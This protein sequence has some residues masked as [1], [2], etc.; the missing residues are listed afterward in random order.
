MDAS[1]LP[2]SD[3][4][5]QLVVGG[6]V[7]MDL[8]ESFAR[9]LRARRRA[10]AIVFRRNVADLVQVA[11]LCAA[12]RNAA[13][14]ELAPFVAVDQEGGRVSRLPE[15][16]LVLPPMRTLGRIDELGL[17]RRAARVVGLELGALGFN[18]DFAPVLDV[19]SN[20]ANPVIGDRSFGAEPERVARH[21][22]AFIEGLSSSGLCACAKHFPGHG[23]TSQDSH[24]ELPT[25]AHGDERL[26]HIE[27]APF[28]AA[29]GAR[30][31]AM[32]SAHVVV[33]A[34]DAHQPATLSRR[35]CTELLRGE[36]GFEGVLFSDDLEMKAIAR[37]PGVELAAPAAIEAGCDVLLVCRDE[38]LQCRVHEALVRRAEQDGAFEARCRQAARR[39]MDL[40]QRRGG[41]MPEASPSSPQDRRARLQ[42]RIERALGSEQARQIAARLS[43]ATS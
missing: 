25:V 20:P 8:P 19:D 17:T 36:L 16:F 9:E 28:V 42:A 43:R 30:V 13:Q 24:F 31:D 40:R 6:F 27:L 23:D 32:M 4:C 2:L 41:P 15:P 1:T 21:G 7:G 29:I 11:E 18:L 39:S 38:E 3:L 12:I 37:D 14:R 5:G 10:G 35:I 26:R 22:L 33:R 34:W